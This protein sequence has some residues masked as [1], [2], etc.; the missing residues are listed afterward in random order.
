MFSC[1][2]TWVR[3]DVR[4]NLVWANKFQVSDNDHAAG[5]D[6]DYDDDGDVDANS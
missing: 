2:Q 3:I 1:Q 5:Y 4:L 6:D